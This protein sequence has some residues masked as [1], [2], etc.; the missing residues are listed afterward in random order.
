MDNIQKTGKVAVYYIERI[1]TLKKVGSVTGNTY[2]FTKDEKKMPLPTLV[3][4]TDVKELLEERKQK[5][6]CKNPRR[7]FFTQE[8]IDKAVAGEIDL[9]EL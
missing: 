6:K 9:L 2:I 8:E 3:D 5:C 4:E 7:L 1:D